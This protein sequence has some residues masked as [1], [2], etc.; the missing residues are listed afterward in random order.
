MHKLRQDLRATQESI[1]HD[2]DAVTELEE[3]KGRMD[4]TDPRVEQISVRVERLA[5][6]LKDKAGAERA[7]VE[8]IQS[9]G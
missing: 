9:A 3:Q 5:A 7:L 8:E 2:A 1:R 4:P 6:A